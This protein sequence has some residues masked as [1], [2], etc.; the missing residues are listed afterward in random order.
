MQTGSESSFELDGASSLEIALDRATESYRLGVLEGRSKKRA[1]ARGEMSTA[2]VTAR[3]GDMPVLPARLQWRG[4]EVSPEFQAYAARVARGEELAPYRG[5]V[6]A[7][8]TPEF[9]WASF[10]RPERAERTERLD[11]PPFAARSLRHAAW[12]FGMA[13]AMLAAI[14]LGAGAFSSTGRDGSLDF[15]TGALKP[16][17]VGESPS[18]QSG[19]NVRDRALDDDEALLAPAGSKRQASTR[20]RSAATGSARRSATSA[21]AA[22][23]AR[24]ATAASR[25]N[26]TSATSTPESG[27][28]SSDAAHSMAPGAL[29][30]QSSGAHAP[31]SSD[32]LR[33]AVLGNSARAGGGSGLEAAGGGER[34]S[35]LFSDQ[36]SF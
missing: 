31:T 3:Y 22:G 18:V 32:G 8:S 6:L 25:V 7:R 1:S 17:T 2:L 28:P 30:V 36:P 34:D 19:A 13:G 35:S 26:G 27:T 10:Q 23:V 20:T 29:A 4:I 14:G 11:P 9:P 24:L 12:L 33:T 16:A 21:S 5:A 15:A